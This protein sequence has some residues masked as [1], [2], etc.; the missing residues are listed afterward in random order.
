MVGGRTLWGVD[1][2]LAVVNLMA[3]V[4]MVSVGHKFWWIGVAILFH[5]LLR[6]AYKADPDVLKVY[7]HYVLQSHRYEPWPHPGSRQARPKGWG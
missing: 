3:T 1:Y 2:K 7:L 4:V 5:S 6:A